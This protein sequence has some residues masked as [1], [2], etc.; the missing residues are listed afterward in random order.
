MLGLFAFI[1]LIASLAIKR[2]KNREKKE[3][4]EE[5]GPTQNVNN[6]A[7]NKD[8]VATTLAIITG[9]LALIGALTAA[10]SIPA[11]PPDH[12]IYIYLIEDLLHPILTM[13]LAPGMNIL[14]NP[15]LFRYLLTWKKC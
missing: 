13:I 2:E 9:L 10:I 12:D 4:T 6:I 14:S 5:N 7:H 11:L 3:V 1:L 8:V 15:D